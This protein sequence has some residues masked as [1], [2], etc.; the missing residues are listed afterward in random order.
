MKYFSIIR[1][2]EYER[3]EK[4]SLDGEILDVGGSRRSGYHQLISGTNKFTVINIDSECEPD[5]FVNI[6]EQFPFEDGQFDNAICFNV[7]EHVYEFENVVSEQIRCIKPGGKI[8]IATP[9]MHHVHG[10]PDDYLRYTESAFKRM[11][12]KYDCSV[13][14]IE[15]LGDG[16]FSLGFQCV[17]DAI[18]TTYLQFFFKVIAVSLD[19][20]LNK[21]SRRYRQLT[22]RLPLG[23]YVILEK[24]NISK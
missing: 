15:Q 12:T 5:Y 18:P 9:F 17:G 1:G 10:S 13:E 2:A 3:L 23:Y 8:V 4:L 6:E 11:A 22:S 24:T 19:K 16:F 7:L 21:I 14:K 20:F